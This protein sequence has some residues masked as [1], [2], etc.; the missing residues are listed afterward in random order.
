M[1]EMYLKEMYF[2]CVQLIH[3]CE[4]FNDKL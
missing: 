2:M 4:W 1:K 3:W